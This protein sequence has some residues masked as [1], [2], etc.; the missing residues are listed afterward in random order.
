M[1]DSD[2]AGD[3]GGANGVQGGGGRGGGGRVV[4][5]EAQKQHKSLHRKSTDSKHKA[6]SLARDAAAAAALAAAAAALA[7][8]VAT[9]QAQQ[10][11]IG[12]LTQALSD[13]LRNAAE[14]ATTF[15]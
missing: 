4:L 7:A 9:N 12:T 3:G 11:Q 13:S 15:E 10:V 2:G 6:D 8:S 14:F 5:T 1:S